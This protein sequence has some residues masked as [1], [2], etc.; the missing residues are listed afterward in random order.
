[1]GIFCVLV[2][3][4]VNGHIFTV[5]K[6]FI[7]FIDPILGHTVYQF[8]KKPDFSDF[9]VSG[10]GLPMGHRFWKYISLELQWRQSRHFVLVGILAEKRYLYKC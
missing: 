9:T 1:M 7:Y 4:R 10:F 5:E 2:N 3:V 8:L 6:S